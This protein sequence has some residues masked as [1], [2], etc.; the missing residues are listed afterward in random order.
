VAYGAS[1]ARSQAI[2]NFRKDHGPAIQ[3]A[4]AQFV[5][6]CRELGLF[7]KALVALDGSKF[8]AVNSRDNN[9]TLWPNERMNVRD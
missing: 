9:F 1:G 3:Q 2:A 6:L 5:G 4:C 8:K 7:S